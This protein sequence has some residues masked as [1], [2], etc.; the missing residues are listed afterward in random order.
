MDYQKRIIEEVSGEFAKLITELF[1]EDKEETKDTAECSCECQDGE[2]ACGCEE[3]FNKLVEQIVE[4]D[5]LEDATLVRVINDDVF[6]DEEEDYREVSVM[7]LSGADGEPVEGLVK[8]EYDADIED[9]SDIISALAYAISE[10]I[11]DELSGNGILTREDIYEQIITSVADAAVELIKT[12][13]KKS[14]EAVK[15]GKVRIVY[16]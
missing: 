8:V 2:C 9:R 1:T 7:Y 3:M 14:A 5:E 16:D 15:N 10:L 6:C 13:L 11:Y 12:A 4:E